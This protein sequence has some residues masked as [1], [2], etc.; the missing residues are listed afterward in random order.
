M[1]GKIK[2]VASPRLS[3]NLFSPEDVRRLHAATLDVIETVGVRFPSARAQEIW[4]SHGAQVDKASGIVKVPA[5]LIEK[6]LQSAPPAYSLAARDPTQD[7]PL[8][9]EHV[10]VGTDG[11]GVEIIDLFSGERRRSRLQDVEEI[12][13]VADALEEVAFH[14]VPLSA[15][16]KPAHTRGLHELAAVWR[17]STKHVQTE[18]IYT[19]HEA[20]A[21]VEMAAVLAG[22]REA[23]RQRPLLSLMQCTA[24][25]LAHDAGSLDAALIGAEA[26]LP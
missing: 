4:A 15:Q 18:S 7:L 6:A 25:P 20:K 10:W 19:V 5:H 24:P 17:N 21:A 14:W 23:L 8:D 26:G 12:A 1:S 2:S 3:L 13:R 22:G 11:C 9:G 16:D